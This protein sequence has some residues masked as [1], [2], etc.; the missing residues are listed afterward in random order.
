MITPG[1][2]G[3]RWGEVGGQG[4]AILTFVDAFSLTQNESSHQDQDGGETHNGWKGLGCD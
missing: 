4:L 2:R 1:R 3:V